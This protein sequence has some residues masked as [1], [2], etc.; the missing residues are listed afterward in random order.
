MT[1]ND[2]ITDTVKVATLASNTSITLDTDVDLANNTKLFFSSPNS[3]ELINA[4]KV[5][6]GNDIIIRGHL[7][8][9]V[10]EEDVTIPILIDNII[11]A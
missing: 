1:S 10:V 11:T 8:A 2:L 4:S 5:K 9:K 6:S 7:V 3:F